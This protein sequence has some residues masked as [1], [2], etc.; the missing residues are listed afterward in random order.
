[1]L[2]TWWYSFR[3]FFVVI[4]K[5]LPMFS[6]R[7]NNVRYPSSSSSSSSSSSLRKT[8]KSK[9]QLQSH[10]SNNPLG[11]LGYCC[12]SNERSI[13][14]QAIYIF[15]KPGPTYPSII[16]DWPY[17]YYH[18]HQPNLKELEIHVSSYESSF[19]VI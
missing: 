13:N 3:V 9:N 16:C 5:T 17:Y 4:T 1:M 7:S 19:L 12:Y 10:G 6:G 8:Q 18:H 2:E 15:D 11:I 14:T